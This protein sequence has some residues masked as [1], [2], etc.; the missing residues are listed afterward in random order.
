MEI[1]KGIKPVFILISIA[2]LL[3][4]I[5][6][7]WIRLGWPFPYAQ[8]TLPLV[9]GP[10]MISAFLGTLISLE[11][12]VAINKLWMYLAPLLSG[13]AA[14]ALLFGI[15]NGLIVPVLF[16]L[17]SII[18]VLMFIQIIRQHPAIHTIIMGLGSL[19]WMIGNLLWLYSWPFPQL[20]LWWAA[21]L[22][23][24][25][26]GERLELN[27]ILKH[28][29]PVFYAFDFI[30]VLYLVGLSLSAILLLLGTRINSLAMLFLAIW[31]FLFD[32]AR[33]TIRLSELPR[34]IAFCLITGYIWLGTGGILG[35]IYGG[36]SAG[37]YYD[38]FLHAIFVGYVIS[39]IFG[40][41]PIIFPSILGVSIEY[42]K[43][44][45]IPLILLHISLVLRISGD[46][47]LIS[48]LRLVGG[49]LNGVAIV[50]FL[51][52]M[53]GKIVRSRRKLATGVS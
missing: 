11:R 1:L 43:I 42:S 3:V 14:L 38:A 24:T 19:A 45:Y 32:I 41:G 20:V 10:L 13:L 46:L 48:Q 44:L 49:L 9:H 50:L 53:A 51:I 2:A 4:A 52:I 30:I 12:A 16:S 34:Y 27:R 21:F 39:M 35:V 8:P 33:K 26:A 7:G 23:L 47:L 29:K 22:V 40:H 31:L 37:L 25:I 28:P 5:W 36:Y 6:A 15:D 18:L 17:S